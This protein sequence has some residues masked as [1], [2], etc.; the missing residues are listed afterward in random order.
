MAHE[1]KEQDNIFY[2][3]W[4]PDSF[5]GSDSERI[6]QAVAAAADAGGGVVR[7]PRMNDNNGNL[8][9]F[10]LL[11]SAILMRDHV[12]LVLDQCCLKLSDRC[13]DN[14]IRSANC[15]LG[16]SDIKPMEDIHIRG[17][18]RVVLEG[19][20][21]PRATGDSAKTLG[22]RTFGTDA[23]VAGESQKG[24]WRNIGILL[25]SVN[26]FSIE[27]IH[28]RDAHCWAIS[29]E[30]CRYGTIRDIDFLAVE[31]ITVDGTEH[32]VLNR[33][34]LDL[35]RGCQYITVDG[36]TGHSGDD[37][38]AL[39][40]I[41]HANRNAGEICSTEVSGF[42]GTVTPE[43]YVHHIVIRNVRGYSSGGHHIVRFLNAGGVRMHDILLDGVLDTSE[44]PV[45]CKAAVK[46]G[47]ANPAWGGVTPMG[48]TTRFIIRNVLTRARH[49]VLIGGSL[50]DSVIDGI[51]CHDKNVPPVTMDS[52]PENLRDVRIGQCIPAFK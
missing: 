1:N 47:D 5:S 38:V 6:N 45:Q 31:S 26:H 52:G 11:D 20:D 10:W 9:D 27:N 28:I 25:A 15:G 2:N 50:A 14:F 22:E 24:D 21:H 36:V 23:G 44:A 34:G 3:Y 8:R 17:V 42:S 39:T 35:R 18:G 29:L 37:L 32:R 4:T 46:I 19:A 30:R 51:I 41:C 43:D 12:T 49:A 40:A 13:R 48:D 16:I 33:D 7:V